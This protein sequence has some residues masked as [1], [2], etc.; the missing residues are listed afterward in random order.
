MF[1]SIPLRLALSILAAACALVAP[2]SPTARIV[3]AEVRNEMERPVMFTVRQSLDEEAGAALPGAIQPTSMP[4]ASTTDVT[5]HV[6]AAG[7]WWLFV[8]ESNT[9]N[10]ADIDMLV[11]R[12]CTILIEVSADGSFHLDCGGQT[13]PAPS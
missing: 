13:S 11:E 10:G 6:P 1:R 4:A 3:E 9:F 7:P 5:F 2:P 8:G 12:G